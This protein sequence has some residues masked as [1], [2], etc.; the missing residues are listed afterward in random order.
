MRLALTIAGVTAILSR[1][2]CWFGRHDWRI[3]DMNGPVDVLRCERCHREKEVVDG[4]TL[5]P[6][7]IVPG[8]QGRKARLAKTIR[9]CKHDGDRM[10]NDGGRWFCANCGRYLNDDGSEG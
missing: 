9:T 1:A 4:R 10:R 3:S 5:P 2:M 6:V 7:R 8:W